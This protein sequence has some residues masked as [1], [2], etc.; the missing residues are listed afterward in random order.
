MTKDLRNAIVNRLFRNKF[1]RNETSRKECK[2]SQ[3]FVIFSCEK[4][5][6][7]FCKYPLLF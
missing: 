7:P 3:I 5:K 6:R 4:Q 2:N 1:L